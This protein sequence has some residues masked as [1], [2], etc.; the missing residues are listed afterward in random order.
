MIG[1]QTGIEAVHASKSLLDVGLGLTGALP[2]LIHTLQ[3]LGEVLDRL[4]ERKDR[5]D[6]RVDPG[7]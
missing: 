2:Q 1:E 6:T 7:D 4:E 5:K 3:K